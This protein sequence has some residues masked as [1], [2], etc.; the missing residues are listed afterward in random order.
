M[1][2][3]RRRSFALLRG[4]VA[5][6]LAVILLAVT[7]F[8]AADL[9]RGPTAVSEG[10]ALR[11]GEYVQVDIQYILRTFAVERADNGAVLSFYGAVP[12]GTRFV[13]VRFTARQLEDA[14]LIE[15]ETADFLTGAR[16][17]M[18]VHFLVSGR[19][20]PVGEDVAPLFRQWFDENVSWMTAAGVIADIDDPTQYLS[21]LVIEADRVGTMSYGWVVGLSVMAAALL[22]YALG[23]AVLVL[24]GFYD[25]PTARERERARR[26]AEKRE[27]RRA[28]R[29][30]AA[31][32]LRQQDETTE[33]VV[34]ETT[35]A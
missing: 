16:D 19:V 7:G 1:N 4:C 8:G 20:R 28:R 18:S 21:G 31:E 27:A 14:G 6:A 12:M 29:Q 24:A 34:E 5:I 9:L 17:A 26:K 3:K 35:D 25:R 11:A 22:L 30:G 10:T 32:A 2:K 15:S 33:T 13:P 23:E